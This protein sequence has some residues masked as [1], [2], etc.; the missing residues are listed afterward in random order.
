MMTEVVDMDKDEISEIEA[1]E[2][3]KPQVEPEKPVETNIPE[4]YRGKSMEE[5]VKMHVSAEQALSRQGNELGEVRRLAD[6]L[7]KSQL[8]KKQEEQALP[9]V[10]FFENPQEAIRRAVETNPKVIAAEQYSLQ[11]QKERA[12]SRLTEKH[13]DYSDVVRNEDF[14]NWVKSSSKRM[15]LYQE[16]EAFDFEAADELLSTYKQLKAIPS[17]ANEPITEIDTKVRDKTLQ[18]AAVDIGGSGEGSRK[19]YRRSDLIRL[20][21]NDPQRYASMQD[22]IDRAYQEGRIK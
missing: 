5:I 22:E 12:L 1:V 14:A 8:A 21:I 2:T 17:K 18:A 19:V 3:Q 16:A 15:R 11:A 7:L 6:E 20:K 10:D 4:K 9:E 13:P